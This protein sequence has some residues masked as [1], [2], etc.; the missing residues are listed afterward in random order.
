MRTCLIAITAFAAASC[1][2][3]EVP[4]SPTWISG[5]WLSCSEGMQVVESWIDA[6]TGTL[7]GAN[8]TQAGETG[9]EFLRVS[10]NAAGGYSYFAAPGGGPATEFRMTSNDG[11]RVVFENAGNDFPQKI[12]YQREEDTLRAHIEGEIDGELQG[13]S[14]SFSLES[15]N[16]ACGT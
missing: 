1:A 10:P 8:L 11:A 2:S 3:A 4:R 5:Y 16:A 7:L 9:F 12:I 14:W 15:A 6:G 13:M